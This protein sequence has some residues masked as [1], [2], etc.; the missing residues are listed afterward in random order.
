VFCAKA[1]RFILTKIDSKMIRIVFI[2]LNGRFSKDITI[3]LKTK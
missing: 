3:A 2:F 1:I